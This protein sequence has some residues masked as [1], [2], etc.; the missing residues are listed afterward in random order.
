MTSSK[1]LA[2]E[3]VARKQSFLKD[4][5]GAHSGSRTASMKSPIFCRS[6]ECSAGEPYGGSR[7]ICYGLR[8]KCTR[9]NRRAGESREL[10][11]RLYGFQEAGAAL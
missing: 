2:A 11:V 6:W 5:L 9:I 1:P 3:P 7:R 10:N 4:C 8:V